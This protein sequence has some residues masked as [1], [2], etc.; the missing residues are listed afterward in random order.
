MIFI[1]VI[2]RRA[3]PIVE[4]H[5]LYRRTNRRPCY[6]AKDQQ[7]LAAECRRLKS[8]LVLDKRLLL[9]ISSC[10]HARWWKLADPEALTEP[11]T[12]GAAFRPSR[13]FYGDPLLFDQ[14]TFGLE[15]KK[16]GDGFD[17]AAGRAHRKW[18]M[19]V[20]P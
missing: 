10:T 9:E 16:M 2:P 19:E 6:P 4:S 1:K 8:M 7:E 12:Q 15:Q 17:R 13:I 3:L 5:L 20:E 14:A 11:L 18:R